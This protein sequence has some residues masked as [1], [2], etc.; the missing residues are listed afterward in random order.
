MIGRVAGHG[1]RVEGFLR[2]PV[3]RAVFPLHNTLHVHVRNS[4]PGVYKHGYTYVLFLANQSLS[5]GDK[6]N[7]RLPILQIICDFLLTFPAL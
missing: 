5:R 6:K 2:T 3:S 4:V 7:R 1:Q